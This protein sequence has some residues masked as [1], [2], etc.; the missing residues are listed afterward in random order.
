MSASGSK[1]LLLDSTR[2]L[3]NRWTET[4]NAWRDAK[5]TEFEELYLSELS[6]NVHSAIRAI[7]ELEQILSKIHADCE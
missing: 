5:A 3:L 6:N 7:D 2:Q 1:G 4:R